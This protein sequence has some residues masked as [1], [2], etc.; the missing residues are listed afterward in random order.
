MIKNII[1]AGGGL[2]GWAYVGTIQA[3]NESSVV[4]FKD[5]E[6][7]IGVSIGSLFGLMYLLRIDTDYL[8]DFIMDLDYTDMVDVDIDN[9]LNNQS[10][11]VGRRYESKIRELIAQTIDPD[12]TFNDLRKYSK[13]LFTVNAL[14]ITYSKLE[15]FNYLL[16]PDVKV[17]DAIRASSAIPVLLPPWKI[18]ECYYY[19]GGIINNCP[20]DLVEPTVS[21]AFNI[22]HSVSHNDNPIKLIDLMIAITNMS[23]KFSRPG[24]E[25]HYSILDESFQHEMLNLKQNKDSIFNL[26]LHGYLNTREILL[27]NYIGLPEPVS[28]PGPVISL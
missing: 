27:K 20:T 18:G 11:M 23:N 24:E 26:Y 1:F 2:K 10:V 8:L 9:I 12:I 6:Q 4:S 28:E 22:A 7:I 13:I 19:D 14:N 5:L 16:T 25:F 17:V 21:I 15:Y 3:L